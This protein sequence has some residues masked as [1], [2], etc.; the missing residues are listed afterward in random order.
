LSPRYATMTTQVTTALDMLLA[1][2]DFI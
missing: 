2:G 1:A